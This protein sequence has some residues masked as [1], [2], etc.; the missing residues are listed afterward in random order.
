MIYIKS[1]VDSEGNILFCNDYAH[2]QTI[3]RWLADYPADSENRFTYSVE[4]EPDI[5]AEIEA[6]SRYPKVRV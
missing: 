4:T 5:I 6:D 1:G 3:V 2:V